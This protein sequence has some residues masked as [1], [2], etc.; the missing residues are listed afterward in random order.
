[1]YSLSYTYS[2]TQVRKKIRLACFKFWDPAFDC[3]SSI[4][5]CI[6]GPESL[7]TSRHF[8]GA[9]RQKWINTEWRAGSLKARGPCHMSL[10]QNGYLR[11]VGYS[12]IDVMWFQWWFLS[13]VSAYSKSYVQIKLYSEDTHVQGLKVIVSLLCRFLNPV[14]SSCNKGHGCF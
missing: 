4:S 10:L 13:A 9:P 8:W 7:A 6:K 11:S 3:S 12:G 5:S 2:Y 1:M 14:S